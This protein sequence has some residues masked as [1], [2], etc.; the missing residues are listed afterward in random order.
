MKL[1]KLL[2]I[3]IPLIVLISLT[4][5]SAAIP[6]SIEIPY[7]DF[8]QDKHFDWVANVDYGDTVVITIG[9]NPTTGFTW[10]DIAQIGD[11]DILK[12]ISHEFTP[13]QQTGAVGSSGKD[14]WT[15]KTL[16]KGTTSIAMEYSQPWDGGEKATWTFRALITV[17]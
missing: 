2:L 16:K 1:K 5:C 8:I 10:P 12:Q 9:S 17:K 14:T 7:D 6:V 3:C 4:A 11:Q 15:F 13:S